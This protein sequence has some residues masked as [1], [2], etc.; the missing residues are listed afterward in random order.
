MPK[1]RRVQDG[2]AG[3]DK[4]KRRPPDEG[5]GDLSEG[6]IVAG[7]FRIERVAG[8]GGM[9]AV[10]RAHDEESNAPV[11]MKVLADG[12]GLG[13]DQGR[14]WREAQL[15]STLRH[16]RIVAYVSQGMVAAGRPYLVMEWLDGED[17]ATRLERGPVSIDDGV[18]IVL[19]AAEGL[20][21]AHRAGLI[22]RD[23]KPSNLFL[24]GGEIDGLK[25]LDFGIARHATETMMAL[26][27]TGAVLGT[28]SYMAPEQA[29]GESALDARTDVFALGAVLFH[30]LTGRPPFVGATEEEVRA[31]VLTDDA[32]RLGRLVAG[33]PP[34]LESLVTRMLARER[35]ERPAD[36]GVVSVM[37][38][39]VLGG[40]GPRPA[41]IAVSREEQRTMSVVAVGAAT[42]GAAEARPTIERLIGAHGG[43]AV[44]VGADVLV[45]F[46]RD[47]GPG[48]AARRAARCALALSKALDVAV[49]LATG[50]GQLEAHVP[51]GPVVDRALGLTREP[52][53]SRPGVRVDAATL[54]LLS[55]RFT[56]VRP[57]AGEAVLD[58]E[59]E[60]GTEESQA[61]AA[62]V[63]AQ[64]FVGREREV[65]LLEGLFAE[66]ASAETARA[67]IV[68]GSPGIGK[69]RLAE[70]LVRAVRAR[71]PEVT[72]LRG[73]GDALG[74]GSAFD[75]I[76]PVI[77][78]YFD[79]D[80]DDSVARQRDKLREG[81]A[82]LPLESDLERTG[83]FL[84]EIVGLPASDDEDAALRASRADPM[85]LGDGMR[86]AWEDWLLALSARGPILLV[87]DDVQ[88]GD[89]PSV[90]FVASALRVLGA[91]PLLV[92]AMARPEL[93]R[94]FPSLWS[95]HAPETVELGAL[96]REAALRLVAKMTGGALDP[97]RGAELF[98]RS[99]GNPFILRELVHAQGDNPN[100]PIPEGTQALLQFR[101][102]ALGSVAKRVLR[103]ASIF[104]ESFWP[105]GVAALLG[106]GAPEREVVERTL[107]LLLEREIV[108]RR[109]ASRVAGEREL[110]FCHAL[111]QEAALAMVPEAER[112]RAH[113]HAGQWLE[114]AGET[115]AIV[116]A[117]HFQRGG[118]PERAAVWYRRGAEAALQGADLDKAI[119]WAE[120]AGASE[121]D[122]P[123]RASLL[124][125][126]ADAYY[127]RGEL[128]TGEV[129]A[130]DAAGHS[131]PGTQ[132][133]FL[134][135]AR[136]LRAAGQRS[137]NDRVAEWAARVGAVDAEVGA[138]DAQ[139][140]CLAR[141][142]GQLALS[143]R[144]D[145]A[146]ACDRRLRELGSEAAETD[147]TTMAIVRLRS[148]LAYVQND[149]FGAL[150][151]ERAARLAS[152]RMAD[153]RSVC[154][155][156][157]LLGSLLATMGQ[158]DE[159][160]EVLQGTQSASRR[161]G[162]RYL[163]IWALYAL[164]KVH[165]LGRD[166]VAG[167]AALS[168]V[169]A[170]LGASPRI[171]AGAR[172][173]L[174]LAADLA[175]N[176]SLAEQEARAALETNPAGAVRAAAQAVLARALLSSGRLD[177]ARAA[178][179]E[180]V[181]HT[182]RAVGYQ[183]FGTLIDLTRVEAHQAAGETAQAAS[184][185][186][187][188]RDQLS[189][190]AAKSRDPAERDRFLHGHP[191]HHRI[192]TLADH[193]AA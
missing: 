129:R 186:S 158:F 159:A 6:T 64:V 172:I 192:I 83:R 175:G 3:R 145:A 17:L 9:G 164:G 104:G 58:G 147:A 55:G 125:L 36:A 141:A 118:D 35:D 103:A 149:F 182:D 112:P 10:Y 19:R 140:Q 20:A 11:A 113:W 76:D 91:R 193:D 137:A 127:W 146:L 40:A 119:A 105:G 66:C 39:A 183:E 72:V 71:A 151:N 62:N 128:E 111:L 34:E 122:A 30:A 106:G 1:A 75:L 70:E 179:A 180:A 156:S 4:T 68:K 78:R 107:P 114:A 148:K 166:F 23:V 153:L 101:L 89:V 190:I 143:S 138:R 184:L 110:V 84:G 88:W 154:E 49:G 170:G 134:A 173:Y 47:Q 181:A 63:P 38:G 37:L 28:P 13:E 123:T 144:F 168:E 98:A 53:R 139:A 117:E 24:V 22:H 92:V 60:M 52:T 77:R 26:T 43:R 174:A 187:E 135:V 2:S 90:K 54:P 21:V 15:L 65:A 48:D 8:V 132:A 109:P 116:L 7:R 155:S 80:A 188:L 121:R 86:A 32:P 96:R 93:E 74:M 97:A 82:A 69:S 46:A 51:S 152:K 120:R 163:E 81:L 162:V 130:V 73:R 99:G 102:D 61:A 108:A 171:V 29:R 142:G 131:T 14:F 150:E 165:V 33:V 115:D 25:V 136:I 177:E 176:A 41:A 94:H 124:R 59:L 133:W 50:P 16:P 185:L 56:V 189:Q 169:V 18:R 57:G 79:L 27:Q 87:L 191:Y 12:L 167:R 100:E 44:F 31:R 160:K 161:L 45:T 42:E 126:E 85:L 178:V 95:E 5:A 67:V 157:V